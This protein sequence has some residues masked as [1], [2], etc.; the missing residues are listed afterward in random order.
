MSNKPHLR[1]TNGQTP[2]PQIIAPSPMPFTA[3]CELVMANGAPM[4]QLR[5]FTPSGV[6]V[7]FLT[8]DDARGVANMISQKA[9]GLV[10]PDVG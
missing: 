7:L 10:V 5:F 6:T 9:G 2:E 8:P 3:Q 1:P 4:I